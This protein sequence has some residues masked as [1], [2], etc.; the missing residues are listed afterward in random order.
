M[1]KF[2]SMHPYQN[3]LPFEVYRSELKGGKKKSRHVK[4]N[5]NKKKHIVDCPCYVPKWM[6]ND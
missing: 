1:S 2:E 4:T 3:P 5:E 6:K